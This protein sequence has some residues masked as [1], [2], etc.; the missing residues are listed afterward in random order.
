MELKLLHKFEEPIEKNGTKIYAIRKV[1][2]G[3]K[4]RTENG[5]ILV[6]T[7]IDPETLS[8]DELLELLK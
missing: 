6:E 5:P 4:F 1:F 7:T 2:K 3:I 8:L